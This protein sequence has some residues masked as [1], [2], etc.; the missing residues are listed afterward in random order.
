MTTFK[1]EI[2]S[3]GNHRITAPGYEGEWASY[4]GIAVLRVN[5]K[6]YY[7]ATAYFEGDLPAHKIFEIF[8]VTR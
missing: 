6:T 7:A 1:H 2:D 8:E 5:H 4:R 3:K